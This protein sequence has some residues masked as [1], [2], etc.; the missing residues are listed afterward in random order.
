KPRR[1]PA[2]PWRRFAKRQACADSGYLVRTLCRIARYRDSAQ[3]KAWKMSNGIRH[4]SCSWAYFEDCCV[5][6]LLAAGPSGCARPRARPIA[7]TAGE[8]TE[9]G[10]P[11]Q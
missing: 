7:V 6:V 1:N 3:P 2:L 8:E 9:P 5:A 11:R 4:E 10:G